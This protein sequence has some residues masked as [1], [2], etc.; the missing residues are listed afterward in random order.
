MAISRGG[1]SVI[2]P[3]GEMFRYHTWATLELIDYCDSL[4]PDQLN[5]SVPGT[6]GSITDTLIHVVAADKR[7]LELM[8]GTATPRRAPEDRSPSMADLRAQ[9]QAQSQQWEAMLDR[10]EE[11]DPTIPGREDRPEIP[12]ARNL[13]L[14]QAIHHGNDHRTHICTTLG[15]TGLP[16]PEIDVWTYWFSPG[17]QTS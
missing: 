13:L 4:P 3:L 2:D 12:N 5:R 17:H 10:I 15:A 9:F 6:A 8:T 7:Y 11:Y 1:E 14:T 16:V